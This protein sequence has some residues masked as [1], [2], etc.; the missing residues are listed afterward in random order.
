MQVASST[1]RVTW[2]HTIRD[3]HFILLVCL[4]TGS[5]YSFGLQDG[6]STSL[7]NYDKPDNTS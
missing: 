1:R 7:R 4:V 5:A 2:T 6:G 3:H